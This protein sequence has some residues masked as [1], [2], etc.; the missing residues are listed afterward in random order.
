MLS[1]LIPT[2]NYDTLPLVKSIHKQCVNSDIVFEILVFDDGSNSELSK[3]NNAINEFRNSVFQALDKNIGRTALRNVLAKHAKYDNLLFIDADTLP[4]NEN[5]ISNY[6]GHIHTNY[7]S[8]FGGYAYQRKVPEKDMLLRWKYGKSCEQVDA[9][10]RNR[11]PYKVIIS[12]NMLI[13]KGVF[14]SI[15]HHMLGN[16]YGLDNYFGSLLKNNKINVLHIN[17]AVTHLGLERSEIYLTKKELASETLI[18]LNRENKLPNHTNNLLI[19][20]VF[21]KKYKLNYFFNYF[22]IAF[23]AILKKN[24]LGKTPIVY[25]L[26]LYRLSYMCHKDLNS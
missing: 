13:K 10:I 8:I 25:I 9:S 16:M 11:N 19:W 14:L 26:Q 24:L 22:Y 1:I 4:A 20:F 3:K 12:G 2:F 6:L 5:F 17:N 21:L 23:N 18:K 15:N 7:Q